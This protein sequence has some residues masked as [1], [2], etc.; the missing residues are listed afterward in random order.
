M[1]P[2]AGPA[3]CMAQMNGGL[4]RQAKEPKVVHIADL[5]ARGL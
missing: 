1:A 4:S 5:L 3:G 2:A